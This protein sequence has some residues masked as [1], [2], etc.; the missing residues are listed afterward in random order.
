M[1]IVIPLHLLHTGRTIILWP[2]LIYKRGGRE[3]RGEKY[4]R[5]LS[6]AQQEESSTWWDSSSITTPRRGGRTT[7]KT[8]F[9]GLSPPPY[10]WVK[11]L[12]FFKE[13]GRGPAAQGDGVRVELPHEKGGGES[14]VSRLFSIY[15]FLSGIFCCPSQMEGRMGKSG[16]EWWRPLTRSCSLSGV[17]QPLC[18]LIRELTDGWF[19]FIEVQFSVLNFLVRIFT[20]TTRFRPPPRITCATS[21]RHPLILPDERMTYTHLCMYIVYLVGLRYWQEKGPKFGASEV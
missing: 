5:M 11:K 10:L 7:S 8:I 6:E 12:K 9:A 4:F 14:R 19:R 18:F 15:I 13:K 21:G 1:E 17:L 16:R 20:L 2:T 3:G